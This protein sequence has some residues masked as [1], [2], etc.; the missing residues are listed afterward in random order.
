M[1]NKRKKPQCFSFLLR[2]ITC[3]RKLPNT[4]FHYIQ[5]ISLF[6]LSGQS[7]KSLGLMYYAKKEKALTQVHSHEEN[8]RQIPLF[9]FYRYSKHHEQY[10]YVR[11]KI[12]EAIIVKSM[13]YSGL[14]QLCSAKYT[15][16]LLLCKGFGRAA[17]SL[18]QVFQR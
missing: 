5:F 6:I 7:Y 1:G 14:F 13:L 8:W 12:Y 10:G 11:L 4:Q 17:I 15:K 3:N 18:C 2:M 9:F 16:N